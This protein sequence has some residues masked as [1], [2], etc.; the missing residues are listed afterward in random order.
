MNTLALQYTLSYSF[1]F[2]WLCR[3]LFWTDLGFFFL[4]LHLAVHKNWTVSMLIHSCSFGLI[5]SQLLTLSK[6]R[7]TRHCLPC[8]RRNRSMVLFC[9]GALLQGHWFPKAGSLC[10]HADSF[11]LCLTEQPRA[12]NHLTSMWNDAVSQAEERENDLSHVCSSYPIRQPWNCYHA[13][14]SVFSLIIKICSVER[15]SSSH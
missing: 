7:K 12:I 2:S 1:L 6:P 9:S 15:I 3:T 4:C 11:K 5:R 10:W 13:H 14:D 8:L